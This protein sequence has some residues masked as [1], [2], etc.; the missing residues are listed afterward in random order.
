MSRNNLTVS[1]RKKF[2]IFLTANSERIVI[3][4]SDFEMMDIVTDNIRYN[5]REMEFVSWNWATNP[6]R[7]NEIQLIFDP[8]LLASYNITRQ[9]IASGLSSLN[10]ELTTNTYLKLG[11]DEYAIVI[12]EDLSEEEEKK[13]KKIQI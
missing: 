7:R 1:E 13:K 9:N 2:C 5:L 11:N 3:K 4:G 8:I 12:K 10:R 6:G